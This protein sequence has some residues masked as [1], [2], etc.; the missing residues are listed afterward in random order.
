MT[1][2]TFD[3]VLRA[4]L[5]LALLAALLAACNEGAPSQQVDLSLHDA[6]LLA[7]AVPQ[8]GAVAVALTGTN[9]SSVGSTA[10]GVRA[11]VTRSGGGAT[12]TLADI[13]MPPLAA[14]AENAVSRTATLPPS[15]AP[16]KYQLVLEIDPAKA[17]NL[18]NRAEDRSEFSLT[19]TEPVTSCSAPDEI[20]TFADPAILAFVEARLAS[21]GD[22]RMTCANVGQIT[23][24][25]VNDKGVTTLAGVEHLTGVFRSSLN[26][27]A[28]SDL[29]PMAGMTAL[30]ELNIYGNQTA[31]LAPL[32]NHPT[33][34][35]LRAYDNQIASLAP[36]ASVPNLAHV[37]VYG[38]S[39]TR[40]PDLSGMSALNYL[41]VGGSELSDI[42]GVAGL[43]YV[44]LDSNRL[45]SISA[46][47]AMTGLNEFSVSGNKITEIAPIAANLG[48]AAGD[49]FI[50]VGNCISPTDT[51]VLVPPQT[52]HMLEIQARG[53][54][55]QW[56]P[57]GNDAW[58][59]RGG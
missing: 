46:A 31:N 14:S 11:S 9:E 21:I 20:V 34:T 37:D 50:I 17:V 4:A 22:G 54:N 26:E 56:T 7:T 48:I 59:G 18:S 6:K 28:V 43:T 38:N 3:C 53:V 33:L 19:V 52:Q 30:R 16:G 55:V 41:R 35:Y 32:A 1:A 57:V 36:L 25:N 58:C 5:P 24:L 27:H 49:R 42:G 15:V 47:A 12:T 45:A 51:P 8:G 29:S 10:F 40:V 44:N 39:Y 23:Q 13:L 2:R